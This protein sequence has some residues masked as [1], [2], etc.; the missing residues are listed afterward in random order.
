[1]LCE[2]ATPDTA[3]FMNQSVL[4]YKLQPAVH[5]VLQNRCA[6][7]QLMAATV[8]AVTPIARHKLKYFGVHMWKLLHYG[9]QPTVMCGLIQQMAGN[10]SHPATVVH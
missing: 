6:C 5:K 9:S 3:L 4:C 2:A 1:M 10:S 8:C 7:K